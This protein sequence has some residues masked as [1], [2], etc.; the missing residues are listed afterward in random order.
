MR[1]DRSHERGNDHHG[2]HS[3]MHGSRSA[4][5]NNRPFLYDQPTPRKEVLKWTA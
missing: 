5:V 2:I 4:V 3:R 1:G